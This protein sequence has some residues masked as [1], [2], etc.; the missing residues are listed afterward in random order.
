MGRRRY[1]KDF[2]E[3]DWKYNS[4]QV[5]KFV[6]YLMLGGKKTLA[7]NIFY[8]ALKL[9]EDQ[10]GKSGIKIFNKAIKNASPYVEIKSKRVGGATYQVPVQVDEERKFAIAAKWIIQAARS[11]TGKGMRERLADVLME[12]SNNEG[13]VIR[14]K[15][16][17]HRMAEANK[18]FAHFA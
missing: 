17:M 7:S 10:I 2:L 8:D 5:S 14:K 16:E 11:G 4:K 18:A 12:T 9:A 15:E 6:N 13:S 3:P 1:V